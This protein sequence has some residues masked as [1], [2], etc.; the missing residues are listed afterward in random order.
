MA[1]Q[2]GLSELLLFLSRSELTALA[3]EAHFDKN[4][5]ERAAKARPRIAASRKLLAARQMQF[6]RC[7]RLSGARP[8][9][10]AHLSQEP[11]PSPSLKR[12]GSFASETLA[13]PV[14]F[15]KIGLGAD[16]PPKLYALRKI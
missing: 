7:G 1:L 8:K 9:Q 6:V 11:S 4:R 3:V 2:L 13:M 16:A 10:R 5:T 12:E 14:D 15:S